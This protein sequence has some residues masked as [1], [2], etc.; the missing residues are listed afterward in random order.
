[1]LRA[2]RIVMNASSTMPSVYARISHRTASAK[3]K[4]MRVT[5]SVRSEHAKSLTA[6]SD[7]LAFDSGTDMGKVIDWNQQKGK[8]WGPIDERTLVGHVA[9]RT[10]HFPGEPFRL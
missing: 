8:T 7:C 9:R 10:V 3:P 1:M 2:T 6:L 4:I 5:P